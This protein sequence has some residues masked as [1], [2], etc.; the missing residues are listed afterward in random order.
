MPFYFRD[1]KS[2][3]TDDIIN[4]I[5]NEYYQVQ[6]A[7]TESINGYST[8]PGIFCAERSVSN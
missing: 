8:L 1:F 6:F 5:L 4:G 2:D 3:D 7:T